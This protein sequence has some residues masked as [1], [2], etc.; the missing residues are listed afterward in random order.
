L[1]DFQRHLI[2]KNKTISDALLLLN[3]LGQ[4]AI[5]FVTNTEFELL[6]SITDGDIRRALIKECKLESLVTEIIQPNPAYIAS[7]NVDLKKLIHLRNSNYKVIPILDDKEKKII[8]VLNFRLQR[9]ILPIDCVIMAGG[10]G[11]RLLPLTKDIPKPLIKIQNKAIIDHQI[12]RLIYYGIKDCIISL[13][14][15]GEKIIDFLEDK[16]FGEIEFD[17][18]KETKPLGTIG[19][20]KLIKKFKNETILVCNSDILTNLDL[21]SFYDDFI[22]SNADL[23]VLSI[24][25]II[26]IPYAVME[27]NDGFVTG[28]EEKPTKTYFSNGGFYLMKREITEYIPSN[29]FFNATDLIDTLLKNRLKVRTFTHFGYWNDIGKHEDFTRAQNDYNKIEF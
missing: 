1:K 4:D 28:L 26:E 22:N 24:P 18:I 14:Y 19:S 13:N 20:L 9:S 25:Y 16:K 2:D 17:F 15:L 6:G 27:T 29:V 21:E 10:R 8:G 12:E 23:S 7:H 3:S 5:L 11:T